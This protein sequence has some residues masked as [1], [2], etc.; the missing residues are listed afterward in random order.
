MPYIEPKN[1]PKFD[2][3][4]ENLASKVIAEGTEGRAGNLN[5]SITTLLHKVLDSSRLGYSQYNEIIGMLECAKLE[6]YRRKIA[7]YEDVKIEEN[8]DV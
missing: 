4:I 1:R 2:L 5:Y 8:G 3:E 7:P 6:L